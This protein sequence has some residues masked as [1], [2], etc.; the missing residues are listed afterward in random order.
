MR[1]IRGKKDDRWAQWM[2]N[3]GKETTTCP[4]CRKVHEV[5]KHECFSTQLAQRWRATPPGVK[6]SVV[7]THTPSSVKLKQMALIDEE[8]LMEEF[9]RIQGLVAEVEKRRAA[10]APNVA[11]S[12]MEVEFV[13]PPSTSSSN[14]LI[15]A[16]MPL[17]TGGQSN[18]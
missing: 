5:G 8:K 18:F 16:G 10:A 9:E 13:E 11:T 7:V 2:K 17:S 4:T 15:V 12:N 14:P 3:Q 6:Q 1:L